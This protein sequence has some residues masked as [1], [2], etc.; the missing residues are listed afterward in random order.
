MSS[1]DLL[2]PRIS[3]GMAL[4]M[5]FLGLALAPLAP[6]L[7]MAALLSGGAW[8]ALAALLHPA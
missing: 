1:R 8:M 5:M 6:A 2:L 7:A 3:H 4:L